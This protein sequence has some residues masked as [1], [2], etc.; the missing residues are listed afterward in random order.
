VRRRRAIRDRVA[1]EHCRSRLARN[2][3]TS[4]AQPRVRADSPPALLAGS[5]R[6]LRVGCRST[7]TLGLMTHPPLDRDRLRIAC[8]EVARNVAWR[9]NPVE[10]VLARAFAEILYEDALFHEEFLVGQE[11]D[12]NIITFAVSYLAHAHAIPPMGTEIAW[13]REGLSVLVELCCPN[14][15]GRREDERLYNEIEMGI[16][17]ARGDYEA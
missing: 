11:R 3:G 14:S 17:L 6:A 15:E 5:L 12:P 9:G 8:L 7:R 1:S 10:G 16:S 2:I 13:F 4:D